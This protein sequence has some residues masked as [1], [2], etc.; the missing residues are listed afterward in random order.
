MPTAKE[1]SLREA[2][3]LCHELE[4]Q[5]LLHNAHVGLT[6]SILFKG[7]SDD[8]LDIIVYP[9]KTTKPFSVHEILGVVSRLGFGNFKHGKCYEKDDN[10]LVI[11][12]YRAVQK[13][14]LFFPSK[15]REDYNP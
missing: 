11:S 5:L 12:C 3:V 6:G 2:L 9:S 15:T 7:H 14:D 10:K 8:D 1:W 13:L 4:T